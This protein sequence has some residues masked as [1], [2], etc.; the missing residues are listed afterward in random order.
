[1]TLFLREN[2][3]EV[4]VGP[5]IYTVECKRFNSSPPEPKQ[6]QEEHMSP[7]RDPK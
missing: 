4:D 2:H 7:T 3:L 5:V 1:V 6:H